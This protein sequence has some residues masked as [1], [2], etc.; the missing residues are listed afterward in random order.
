MKN[1]KSPVLVVNIV[2][3]P[4]KPLDSTTPPSVFFVSSLP[5]PTAETPFKEFT[6]PQMDSLGEYSIKA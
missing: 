2:L 4:Q 3:V 1:K 5:V 6:I